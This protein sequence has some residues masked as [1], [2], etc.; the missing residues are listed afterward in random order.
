MTT[1]QKY[2]DAICEFLTS[3][4]L[5]AVA[6]L[7]QLL[8]LPASTIAQALNGSRSIPQKHIFPIL[9]ELARYGIEVEG[10]RLVYDEATDT[11]IAAFADEVET[12]EEGDGFVYF[13]KEYRWI[14]CSYTD[15]PCE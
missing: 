12:K 3:H 5:I 4:H 1:Q 9:C 10:Y 2:S 13:V 7:E 11:I 14:A 8:S 15:L 6:T